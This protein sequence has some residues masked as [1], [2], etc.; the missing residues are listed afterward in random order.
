MS[1]YSASRER[2][3]RGPWMRAVARF[4]VL[5][6]GLWLGLA[7]ARAQTT[8]AMPWMNTALSA[9][10][11]A[12]LVISQMTQPEKLQFVEGI[13]WGV[14]RAGAYVPPED[15]GG[16][17]FVPGVKRLGIPDINLADSAVG[18]RMA[19]YRGRYATLLP[20]ALGA[21]ASWD[22]DGARLY[23]DVIG[24]ELRA[25][26]FNMSIGGG[27]DL[28]REPRNGRNFEYAG[29]D[30]LLAGTMVGNLMKG[31]QAEQVMGD[32]KHYA[33]NDQ[34]T[35]R[36]VLNVVLD[37]KAM[38]ESD[39][40]AFQIAI[41]IAKPSAVMCS[42]NKVDGDYACE[43]DYLLNQVLKK[44]WGFR[45]WVMSDWE[46]TH[47]TVKAALNGLD[48]EQPGGQYFNEA[49]AKAVA[50][51]EVPQT[52]L[53]D[54]VHRVLRSMF[55]AGVVDNPPVP[56]VLDPFK[57]RDDAQHIAEEG[58]VLLRN[59]DSVLPLSSEI[60]SI[61][62]IGGHADVGVLSGAGSAQVDAPGG[63]AADPK[64]GPTKWCEPVYFPSSPLKEL[65]R[66]GPGIKLTYT[67]DADPSRAAAAARAADVAIVFATQ[68]MCESRDAATLL[69]PGGQNGLVSAVAK[70][71]PRTIVVLETGGPVA[72][73]WRDEV[74]GIVEAW[75][76]GIGGAQALANLLYGKVN[77]SGKLP[78]TFAAAD[79]DLPHPTVPGLEPRAAGKTGTANGEGAVTSGFDVNY[80][81]GVRFGY[82]WF[83]SENKAPLYPFGFGLSYTD[84]TY[85]GLKVDGAKRALSFTVKNTG[86]VAG[87]EIAQVYVELPKSAGENFKRMVGW[88]RVSLSPGQIRE[89][90]VEMNKL[91]MSVFDEGSNQFTMPKGNYRLMVGS[92][93]RQIALT[94]TM[95]VQ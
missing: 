19:G 77:F 63:N 10:E 30:P 86:D 75:Y 74:A 62:L 64:H 31:L 57:G 43:N 22:I 59:K 46:G 51:G 90:T 20:S 27:V 33:L 81:E 39:L 9:D 83:D 37:H 50:A 15:V 71:N 4:A 45:G 26:G 58:I 2:C 21:A 89:V 11:R 55:A 7:G 67:D 6:G 91:T 24:R 36:N 32:I 69:L 49:L 38:R 60:H 29:E 44:E 61:A 73:P 18:V 35:G 42:Y 8:A 78:V 66:M 65:S 41:G 17:G 52:R 5:A 34:E 23:G 82:K 94:G 48:Q 93:S 13:G 68:H 84:F 28:T 70:A 92:S 76:P 56:A 80:T 88:S 85:S 87:E 25:Q 1:G 54:M 95:E 3:N 53:D 79:A 16:A 72:M 14:L 47:S 40:L 12:T